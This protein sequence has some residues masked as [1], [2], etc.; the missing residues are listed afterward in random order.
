MPIWDQIYPWIVSGVGGAIG[1]TLLLP[2]KVGEALIQFRTNKLLEKFR[3]QQG[4]ELEQLKA[5]Q[6]RELE[7]LKA[8]QSHQIERLREQL[9]HF[10]DRG[11]RSNE[12]EFN[13]IETVWKHF[14]KAWLSTNTCVSAMISIPDFERM[15]DDEAKKFAASYGFSDDEQAALLTATDRKEEYVRVVRWKNTM[16]A[17]NDIYQAR[18]TLREQRIFMP[19]ELTKQF[20]G[21][22][23][24]MSNVQIEQRLSLAHRRDWDHHGPSTAWVRDCTVVFEDMAVKANK[25][26]FRD[27]ISAGHD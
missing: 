17:G 19:P 16:Q 20:G 3:A 8:E 18:L 13:A 21:I 11:R 15:S 12:M 10:E 27:E 1:M 24:K 23:E 22:I 14:V 2:T 4:R 7:Q 26:L 6:N 5:K 9:S 25:R